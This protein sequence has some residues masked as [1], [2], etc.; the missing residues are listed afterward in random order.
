[1]SGGKVNRACIADCSAA[2]PK[3]HAGPRSHRLTVSEDMDYWSRLGIDSRM[4]YLWIG[5]AFAV[6]NAMATDAACCVKNPNEMCGHL[7]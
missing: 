7:K 2:L 4:A 5:S 3:V 1:M 6:T